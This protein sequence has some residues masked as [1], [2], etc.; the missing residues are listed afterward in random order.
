MAKQIIYGEEARK[1]IKECGVNGVNNEDLINMV[2]ERL[3]HF[4]RSEYACRENAIAITKLEEALLLLA[5]NA[6]AFAS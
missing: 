6:V 3:E 2:I 1:A 4:Q 5:S